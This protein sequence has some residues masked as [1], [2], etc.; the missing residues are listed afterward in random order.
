M[1]LDPPAPTLTAR[2]GPPVTSF[3][4]YDTTLRDGAQQ[5][6]LNLSV[7]DKLAIATL[8]DELGVTF[9]EGG[10]P[11]ANPKDTE[12]FA[13]ARFEL[14]LRN[15]RAG[16][17]RQHPAGRGPG[18]RRPAG[19]S[20]CWT[21]VPRWSRWSASRTSGMSRRRCAPRRRRTWPWSATPSPSWPARAVGCSSTP[22]TSSTDSC[23]TASTRW[24]WSAPRRG[25]G[26]ELVAL[27]DTN[28]G[29]L[30]PRVFDIVS[31]VAAETGATLGIHCHN[32]TGCAVA[33][34]LAAVDAGA[35]HVQG[36]INGY[37]ERTGNADL[38][39]VAAN[40]QLKQ[41]REV[42][43]PHRLGRGHPD[44]A[45]DQRDHQHRAVQS[46]AVRRRQRV[47][48]QGRAARLR[49]QGRCGSLPAHRS[50]A[51]RQ[52]HA[53]AGLRHGRAGVGGA[54]G[55]RA[56]LRPDRPQR[57][58][59]R[60][61]RQG[62]GTRAARLHLRRG[63]RLVRAAAARAARGLAVA[64]LRGRVVAGDHRVVRR[65]QLGRAGPPDDDGAV[66]LRRSRRRRS[67]CGP[68][69]GATSPPARATAR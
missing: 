34:T 63:R 69:A 65:A 26:A 64:L 37:G 68:P 9:I 54:E 29:M 8:L 66:D 11:G 30:P 43:E 1:D 15:A 4:V 3:H 33:N 19:R 58:A 47:R 60:G 35:I 55:P 21:P 48:A 25:A 5:E 67:S 51:G 44:R 18:R 22:S 28:G 61:G 10:W 7:A 62:Q 52:R 12:F 42:L 31:A 56:G 2:N 39:A 59:L 38:I 32:D 17:V 45:R 46:A 6:G 40:L 27:C 14:K 13:R 50:A 24:T 36:C 23:W 49:A 41:G 53:H 16:R 20:H 57:A